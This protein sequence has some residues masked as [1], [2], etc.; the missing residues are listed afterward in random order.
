MKNFVSPHVHVNSLDSASTP[1]AFAE[2]EKELGTGVLTCTDHGSLAAAYKVY[3]LA[4]KNG[5]IPAI[6]IEAYYRSENCPILTK[7]GVP[8]TDKVPK[9]IDKDEWAAKHPGGTFFEYLKYMHCTIGFRDYPSYLVGVKLLSKADL[10][11]ERHGDELKPL[12]D[13]DDL[14]EL[15]GQNTTMG[16]GCFAGMFSRHL[17]SDFGTQ[18]QKADIAKD[19]FDR[20]YGMWGDRFFVEVF[21]HVC[22]HNYISGIFIY[23]ENNTYKY[24][25]GKKIKTDNF[26]GTAED[27]YY[28]KEAVGST[29]QAVK[30]RNIWQDL[31]PEK[32]VKIVKQ[33]GFVQNECTPY[34]PDGDLQLFFNKAALAMAKKYNVPI[35]VS[36]DSHFCKPEQK[37]VQ[38]IRLSNWNG[39]GGFWGSYHRQS[40]DEAFAYFNEKLG[41]D[42]KTFEGWVENSYK[43]AEGFKGFKFDNTIQLPTKFYPKDTLQYTKELILKMGRMPNDPVYKERL[44]KEIELFHRNGTVDLLPYF[45]IDKIDCCD[46]YARQG[47]LTGPGRGSVGGVLLAYLLGITHVDPIKYDLSL[48]RFLTLDRIKSGKWPDVDQD[49]PSRD[50]LTGMETD[51]IEFEMEDGSKHT[52]PEWWKVET[53]LG[54]LTIK[55]A[56]DKGADVKTWW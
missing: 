5:L 31:P 30:N 19:Y 54:D 6:G 4:K 51:I 55:E 43:W 8:K 40:S 34:A 3:D 48:D 16:S 53:D 42:L 38:N 50:L 44:K 14:E 26:E 28:H 17:I 46:I 24:Y 13:W 9:G 47:V 11:A 12:F 23:T 49:L 56:L 33:D 52:L 15:A 45:W 41:I 10:R 27:L 36:D 35:L 39:G 22:S 32:I 37:I 20:L 25:M 1:E 29:L 18:Q 2:R 7:H 21:P